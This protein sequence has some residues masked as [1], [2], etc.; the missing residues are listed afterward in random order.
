MLRHG[1]SGG[2][3]VGVHCRRESD[4]LGTS[5]CSKPFASRVDVGHWVPFKGRLL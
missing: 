3:R 1:S 5:W 2:T 4:R